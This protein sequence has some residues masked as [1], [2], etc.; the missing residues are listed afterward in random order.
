MQTA[1]TLPRK[2]VAL[3]IEWP[4]LGVA[5]AIYSVMGVLTWYHALIPGWLLP[6]LGGYLVCWHGSLQH[7]T[8]HDHPTPW[9][10]LNSALVALP[11]GLWMPYPR[12]REAHLKHHRTSELTVPGHDPES[13]YRTHEQWRELSS[14]W[15]AVLNAN[16]TLIGRLAIGP[17]LV[18]GELVRDELPRLRRLEN[19]VMW[20]RHALG[21]AVVLYWVIG[22]CDMPLWVYLLAFA[23]PGL[24]LT[25]LRSF[26]EHQ[27]AADPAARTNS[28]RAPA[29]VRML[30]LNNNFH[31]AHHACPGVPWYK[32]PELHADGRWDSSY[33][34]L[35]ARFWQR[36][37]SPAHPLV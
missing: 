27:P 8:V 9:R 31:V 21:V 22:V 34:W 6:L 16:N 5:L 36:K 15:R 1:G 12:Y 23:W 29:L 33:A 30:F 14:W 4:T 3:R 19:A 25:L 13:F 26:H 32:L 11:L 28:V 24:S 20:L 35:I 10:C 18:I 7:E 17:L 2:S 37:D